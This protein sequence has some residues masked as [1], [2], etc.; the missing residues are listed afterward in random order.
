M[1]LNI[2]SLPSV[3]C[4][5]PSS[6]FPVRFVQVTVGFGNHLLASATRV[7]FGNVNVGAEKADTIKMESKNHEMKCNLTLY[8]L[9]TVT[10][11][12]GYSS[13]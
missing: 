7:L 4:V 10:P 5:I 2:P 8:D 12:L 1:K 11:G 6:S 9:T 3:N 13:K